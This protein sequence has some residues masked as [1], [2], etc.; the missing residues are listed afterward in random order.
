MTQARNRSFL[1]LYFEH[2]VVSWSGRFEIYFSKCG[3]VINCRHTTSLRMPNYPD[4]GK[5]LQLLC[6]IPGIYKDYFKRNFIL[7]KL[8]YSE[9]VQAFYTS[10]MVKTVIALVHRTNQYTDLSKVIRY[11]YECFETILFIDSFSFDVSNK[12]I[13]TVRYINT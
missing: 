1:L 5:I 10:P 12:P 2:L 3:L 9:S 11:I 7:L 8:W 4:V 6:V 13:E